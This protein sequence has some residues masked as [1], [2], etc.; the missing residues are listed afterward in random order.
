MKVSPLSEVRRP[1]RLHW[2]QRT[3]PVPLWYLLLV[4]VVGT[5]YWLEVILR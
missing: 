5:S 3:V 2:W 4:L 1:Q